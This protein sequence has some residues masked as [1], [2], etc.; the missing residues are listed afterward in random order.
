VF[1]FCGCS[2][3]PKVTFVS[4]TDSPG[5]AWEED[6]D[7]TARSYIYEVIHPLKN[8]SIE[9]KNGTK[10]TFVKYDTGEERGKKQLSKEQ[11]I[12]LKS[13]EKATVELNTEGTV[14]IFC[15]GTQIHGEW[16]NGGHLHDDFTIYFEFTKIQLLRGSPRL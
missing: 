15:N 10:Y 14:K 2:S 13:Q 3:L 1:L 9:L 5:K 8:P 6:A 4:V 16:E 12:L 11:E 7:F